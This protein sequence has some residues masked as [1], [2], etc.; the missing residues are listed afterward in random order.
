MSLSSLLNTIKGHGESARI[1]LNHQN[2]G[3]T[4]FIVFRVCDSS[5][6]LK[7]ALLDTQTDLA[8]STTKYISIYRSNHGWSTKF[9]HV[10]VVTD[11]TDFQMQVT[12]SGHGSFSQ[13]LNTSF[14]TT[15]RTFKHTMWL[16]SWGL[17]R[18]EPGL[19]VTMWLQSWWL[20]RLKPVC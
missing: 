4:T 12:R 8:Y 3:E 15:F 5:W 13:T 6:N 2:I 9:I 1:A 17:S 14:M 11:F 16:Q 10:R 18:L 19:C 20:S 7:H